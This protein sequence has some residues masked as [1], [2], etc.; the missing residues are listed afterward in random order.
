MASS[1]NK[2]LIVFLCALQGLC[3]LDF[4]QTT[5]DF[6]F[7][8]TEHF[9][10]PNNRCERIT[11]PLCLDLEY[12]MTVMPNSLGHSKQEDAALEVHQYIPLVKIDCSPDLKFFLCSVFAPPCTILEE[13][14][15]P[16]RGLCESARR[17]EGLMNSFNVQWPDNLECSQFP[18]FGPE[19]ICIE[20]NAS[21]NAVQPTAGYKPRTADHTRGSLKPVT[22]HRDLGFVCP[23]QLKI[24]SGWGYLLTVGQKVSDTCYELFFYARR[25]T[26][27]KKGCEGRTEQLKMC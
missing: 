20:R 6:H 22:P 2:A 1:S 18:E 10:P 7:D 25:V 27:H 13:P 8:S 16:C 23:V 3:F 12:N 5:A 4:I 15:K 14:I 24:P 11:I 26:K 21:Q 19:S 17:C 9:I